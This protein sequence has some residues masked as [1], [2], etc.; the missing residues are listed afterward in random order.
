MEEKFITVK[1]GTR[2]REVLNA[3]KEDKHIIVLDG[4]GKYYGI[5][6]TD[7]LVRVA[8]NLEAK[9]DHFIVRIKPVKERNLLEIIE[10]M[11]SANI[12]AIPIESDGKLD[13]IDIYEV[14]R[15]LSGDFLNQ[16]AT[17]F[18]HE[19]P[20]TIYERE[21]VTKAIALMKRY[22][23]SRLIVVDEEG[24]PV[25]MITA[26]DIVTHVLFEKERA[27]YGE[28]SE[29]D[30][31]AEVRSIMSSPLIF[32]S[33]G[34]KVKNVVNLLIENKIF[35]VPVITKN[36]IEGIVSAKDIL[37]AYLALAKQMD[38]RIAVH[39]ISFDEYDIQWIK[40][41]FERLV[42]VF[43]D[44]IGEDPM[45]IIHVKRVGKR[46][47]LVRARLI[48]SKV[49]LYATKESQFLYNALG[50]IFHTFREDLI[51]EKAERDRKFLFKKLLRESF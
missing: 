11:I 21:R 2:V 5:L 24:K 7:V 34:E 9:I 29:H 28:I 39:G 36:R 22:G 50:S 8:F 3:I 32:V 45:L 44:I 4:K 13:V 20:I 42:K 6:P 48:G 41:K 37:A 25:G 10:K 18:M 12:R 49:S 19:N 35:A 23:V 15:E 17:Q 46:L 26:K 38:L 1:L 30:F 14:L 33:K 51:R 27:T 31:S 40:K 16:D 47:F 43:G